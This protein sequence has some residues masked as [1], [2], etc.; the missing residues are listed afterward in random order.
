MRRLEFLVEKVICFGEKNPLFIAILNYQY[1]AMASVVI[2]NATFGLGLQNLRV[3]VISEDDILHAQAL[4]NE[5]AYLFIC[6]C[7]FCCRGFNT[8]NQQTDGQ[9]GSKN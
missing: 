5:N 7:C 4:M 8:T 2:N 9:I 1:I 6:Y 3:N